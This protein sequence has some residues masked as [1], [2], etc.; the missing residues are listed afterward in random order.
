MN[1]VSTEIVIENCAERVWQVLTDFAA[2]PAW[3]PSIRRAA[4]ELKSGGRLDLDV[5]V[6]PFLDWSLQATI[7]KA[8]PYREIRWKANFLFAWLFQGEHALMIQP[9]AGNR[10]RFIQR[11]VYTGILVPILTRLLS[12]R[13]RRGFQQMNYALKTLAERG[14]NRTIF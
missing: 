9:I 13:T 7:L 3:N 10:V 8:E 2:Y 4:G 14:A 1:E 12:G 11:E 5:R 6:F